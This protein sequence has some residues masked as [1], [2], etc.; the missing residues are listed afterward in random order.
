MYKTNRN[1][2]TELFVVCSYRVGP[3]EVESALVSH[4]A[5]LESAVV[6]SPDRERGSVNSSIIVLTVVSI[7]LFPPSQIIKA[8]VVLSPG[9]EGNDQ[10]KSE[11]QAH[12][13]NVTAPYKYPRKV[14]V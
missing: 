13:R 9:Y 6:A 10:L 1:Y 4:E 14:S 8:F 2:E 11:L 7:Q 5:V 3:F 12:V